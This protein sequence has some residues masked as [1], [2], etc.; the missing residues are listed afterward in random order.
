LGIRR[1]RKTPHAK[2]LSAKDASPPDPLSEKREGE[3]SR[4]G[5]SPLLFSERG[6]RGEAEGE[7]AKK[8]GFKV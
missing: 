8:G 5:K 1:S 6:F 4:L 3:T 2:S 7:S